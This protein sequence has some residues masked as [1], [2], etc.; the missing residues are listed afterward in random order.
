MPMRERQPLFV[1]GAGII[2]HDESVPNS[3]TGICERRVVSDCVKLPDCKMTD[4]KYLIKAGKPLEE[5]SCQLIGDSRIVDVKQQV[6]SQNA[7]AEDVLDD[8]KE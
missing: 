6:D 4:L 3:Q 8:N 1:S 2:T 5:V 7:P